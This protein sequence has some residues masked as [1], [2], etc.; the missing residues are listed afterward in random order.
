MIEHLKRRATKTWVSRMDRVDIALMQ[1][2][3]SQGEAIDGPSIS[4]RIEEAF[5]Q[6]RKMETLGQMA[7]GLAHDFNN[8]LQGVVSALDMM[9]TRI[10][11]GRTGDLACLPKVALLSL[12][13]AAALAHHILSFSRPHAPD[14]KPIEVNTVV[15]STKD[16]LRCVLGDQIEIEIA[17]AEDL[18]PATCDPFQLENALLNLAINARDA[19]PNGGRL[20]I[21]TCNASLGTEQTDLKQGRYVGICVTDDGA[22]MAPEVIERAFDPFYTTKALGQG[23]GLGLAMTK[24]FVEQVQG[25]VKIESI[26]DQGTSI[27]LYLPCTIEGDSP[28]TSLSPVRASRQIDV[29]T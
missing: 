5:R 9:K 25:C 18:P 11:Q 14:L 22:G 7:G 12:D 21:E 24:Y 16:L 1:R 10:N 27:T 6:A 23:T 17:L 8:M 3:S 28:N 4:P 13:R 26:L 20:V 2:A 19:M 15:V 29:A